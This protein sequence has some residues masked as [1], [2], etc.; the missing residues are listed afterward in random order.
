M[1]E[2]G[3]VTEVRNGEVQIEIDPSNMCGACAMKEACQLGNDSV[4]RHLWARN[5][6]GAQIGDLV[7]IK[8]EEGK[9]VF[10]AFMIFIV[11]LIA[12]AVGYLLA[13]PFGEG[14]GVFGAFAGIGFGL[15]LVRLIDKY[16]GRKHNFQPFVIRVL[17]H[18]PLPP[19]DT[20]DG[21]T[22]T[23]PS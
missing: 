8:L 21:E 1:E 16:F 19:T 10:S 15:L 6:A 23:R 4:K 13:R 18:C 14:W 22:G 7:Q 9:A 2:I 20:S 5:L 12:L 17:E 11:P 3:V